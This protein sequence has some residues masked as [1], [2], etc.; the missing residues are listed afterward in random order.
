[1]DW[2]GVMWPNLYHACDSCKK[3]LRT[4][5]TKNGQRLLMLDT[6]LNF[7]LQVYFNQA[8]S[9]LQRQ[10]G[11]FRTHLFKWITDRNA[12][13]PSGYISKIYE[14]TATNCS[15]THL[16]GSRSPFQEYFDLVWLDSIW[17]LQSRVDLREGCPP[18]L[19]MSC[20]PFRKRTSSCSRG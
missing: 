4:F 13:F 9:K 17:W 6:P 7:P 18:R 19:V 15:E 5:Q 16:S 3:I 10:C 2:S 12:R 8:W 11:Q 14:P 1:M 20:C